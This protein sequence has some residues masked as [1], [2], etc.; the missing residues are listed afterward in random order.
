MNPFEKTLKDIDDFCIPNKIKY[1]IIG[2]L[3]LIFHK[4]QRTTNDIDITLLID[5]E[6]MESVSKQIISKF[7]PIFSDP[8][9]FFQKYFV[10]PVIDEKTEMRID[11]SA[12]L[13]GFD[14]QVIER[15]ERK[16][17]GSLNLPFCTIEDLIVYKLFAAR[18]R[19][20]ADLEEIAKIHKDKLDRIYL[21]KVL[22][23]F[24][25]LERN[26]MISNYQN[27]FL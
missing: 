23:E 11:F 17:F 9:P 12:G 22:N 10:L 27:F 8:I 26:D 14:K 2:G 5:L 19:D 13:T 1:A 3:A 4:I 16:K 15:S 24:S 7:K 21:N 20:M 18:H 6:N 25:K